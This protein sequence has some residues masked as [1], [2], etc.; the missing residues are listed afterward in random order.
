[1][2]SPFASLASAKPASQTGPRIGLGTY[3]IHFDSWKTQKGKN[4]PNLLIGDYTVTE[5]LADCESPVGAK[6]STVQPFGT[7]ISDS[8]V[9]ALILAVLGVQ[10]NSEHVADVQ[11][12]LPAICLAATTGVAQKDTEGGTV[13]PDVLCRDAIVTV[14]P[15][16]NPAKPEQKKQ[17]FSP[18]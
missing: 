13:P 11:R 15:S 6:G 3:K 14:Y 18:A 10:T 4:S 12:N 9:V 5:C 16:K 17:I 2:L 1:M 8:Y 7:E